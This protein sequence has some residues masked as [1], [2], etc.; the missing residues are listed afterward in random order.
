MF[1][2]CLF[3]STCTHKKIDFTN[4]FAPPTTTAFCGWR[5]DRTSR[6]ETTTVFASFVFLRRGNLA[7]L[8]HESH[9][10]L[11]NVMLIHCFIHRPW[12]QTWNNPYEEFE[13]DGARHV[14]ANGF[15]MKEWVDTFNKQYKIAD[16]RVY[17]GENIYCDWILL[18]CSH[19]RPVKTARPQY[20][21]F[22]WRE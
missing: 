15:T 14:G 19:D 3:I 16:V 6:S 1:N 22:S 7:H 5:R 21:L 11:R 10:I 2:F 8:W 4:A 12:L 13:F 18:S 9:G 20:R 17:G